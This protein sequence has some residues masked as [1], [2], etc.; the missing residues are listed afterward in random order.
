MWV[1]WVQQPRLSQPA[2]FW[3]LFLSTQQIFN[4]SLPMEQR[5]D[6]SFSQQHT[7]FELKGEHRVIKTNLGS[8]KYWG[9]HL[10]SANALN[11]LL[12][13]V[14]TLLW[15]IFLNPAG[16]GHRELRP[17]FYLDRSVTDGVVYCSG[18]IKAWALGLSFMRRDAVTL[19]KLLSWKRLVISE[20]CNRSWYVSFFLH[21][22][23]MAT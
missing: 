4:Q 18:R 20:K 23:A 9:P 7:A 13:L 3:A 5:E 2:P 22:T 21:F 16:I 10:T 1:I 8:Q 14:C 15:I 19:V 6:G 12:V 11:S 17:A